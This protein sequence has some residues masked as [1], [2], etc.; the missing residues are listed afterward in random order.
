[1]G[2]ASSSKKVARAAGTGGGRTNRSSTPW[3]Y[4]GLIALIVVLGV[5]LT[6][7][8]RTRAHNLVKAASSANAA[9]APTV[10]GTAWTEGFG[11]SIC[12]S[13]LPAIKV[14]SDAEGLTTAGNG[15]I[16]IAPKVKAAAGKNATLGE[17]AKS[18]GMT[19][20]ASSLQVPGGKKYTNG[21]DCSG[22]AAKLY[23]KQYPYAGAP[24]GKIATQDPP[25]IL[26]ADKALVTIAFVPPADKAKIPAPPASVVAALKK[27]ST[28]APTTTTTVAPTTPTTA[29]GS[30]STT[31]KSPSTTTKSPST[32]TK[33]PSTTAKTS[34]TTAK[35]SSTTVKSSPTT[36]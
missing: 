18:I 31:T 2:K 26:L 32:T 12:N 25:S 6:F 7:T 10:G 4:V 28:P 8:S 29:K 1:M 27:A 23:V 33:T 30:S 17:L 5:A 36:T 11:V 15:V 19:L 22:K 14:A 9:V 16:H 20:T 24:T 34:S 13:F 3:T 21:D 35:T